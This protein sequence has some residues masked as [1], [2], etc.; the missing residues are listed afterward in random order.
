[1]VLLEVVE[2]VQGART[3]FA[4][5]MRQAD[6]ADDQ[7]RGRHDG[8]N[9]S[10]PIE[11]DRRAILGCNIMERNCQVVEIEAISFHMENSLG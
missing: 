6:S 4:N 8:T 11:A 10:A 7:P 2:E 9:G 1:M 5:V 3:E